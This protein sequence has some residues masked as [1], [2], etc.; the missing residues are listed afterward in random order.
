MKKKTLVLG[1]STNPERFSFMAVRKLK[2]GNF[3]VVAVGLREGEIS[4]VRI[5]T[6]FPRFEEIHTVTIDIGAKNLTGYYDYILG[7]K[8]KRVIFN[9]GTESPALA[10]L[11]TSAG[12]E[13]V[14]GCTLIMISNNLY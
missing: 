10:E 2:Y 1:A 13:V 7:L 9:P 12:V 11:L 8:P 3:P 4:G 14:H 5:E 6:D